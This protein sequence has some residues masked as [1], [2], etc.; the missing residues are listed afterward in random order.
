[1]LVEQE[2]QLLFTSSEKYNL[3]FSGTQKIAK[4]FFRV[5]DKIAA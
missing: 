2:E 1:M 5:F 3:Y 4:Q